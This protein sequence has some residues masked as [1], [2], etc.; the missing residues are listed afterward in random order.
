MARLVAD[1]IESATLSS[2][3]REFASCHAKLKEHGAGKSKSKRKSNGQ[4]SAASATSTGSHKGKKRMSQSEA[5]Q[6]AV[7]ADDET[8]QE[9]QDHEDA[10]D[11]LLVEFRN[12]WQRHSLSN[13]TSALDEHL[14]QHPAI[15]EALGTALTLL[16]S[17]RVVQSKLLVFWDIAKQCKWS[18]TLRQLY[19]I[20]G[21]SGC[22]SYRF[23]LALGSLAQSG[24]VTFEQAVQEMRTCQDFRHDYSRGSVGR[25]V[26]RMVEW[27]PWDATKA[28]ENFQNGHATRHVLPNQHEASPI[29]QEAQEAR[30]EQHVNGSRASSESASESESDSGSGFDSGSEASASESGSVAEP[31]AGRA[32]ASARGDVDAP[33]FLSGDTT[34]FTDNTD[35]TI[36]A[37]DHVGCGSLIITADNPEHRTSLTASSRLSIKSFPDTFGF[38]T[39]GTGQPQDED[40]QPPTFTQDH[41]DSYI[42][43][44]IDGP[45][46]P[47]DKNGQ[48]L[49]SIDDKDEPYTPLQQTD[50]LRDSPSRA[51]D[52][53]AGRVESRDPAIG[54]Q[55]SSDICGELHY[56]H[57]P[58]SIH[59]SHFSDASKYADAM[60]ANKRGLGNM[61]TGYSQPPAS[62]RNK[63]GDA[64]G[65]DELLPEQ[66]FSRLQAT[67]QSLGMSTS[68]DTGKALGFPEDTAVALHD[69][70][71]GEDQKWNGSFCSIVIYLPR[72]LDNETNGEDAGDKEAETSAGQSQWVSAYVQLQS[73]SLT[74]FTLNTTEE[75]KNRDFA[76]V[77]GFV[78]KHLPQE[79][80]A[81]QDETEPQLASVPHIED[82]HIHDSAFIAGAFAINSAFADAL[83]EPLT[84]HGSSSV[85]CLTLMHRLADHLDSGNGQKR[86]AEDLRNSFT[87]AVLESR[88]PDHTLDTSSGR[89]E[90][91]IAEIEAALDDDAFILRRTVAIQNNLTGLRD[92]VLHQEDKQRALDLQ[93]QQNN[94]D[95][96]TSTIVE[97]NAIRGMT[98]LPQKNKDEIIASLEARRQE[99]EQSNGR[100]PHTLR[101]MELKDL[102]TVV[103]SNIDDSRRCLEKDSR[104]FKSEAMVRLR[105][106]LERLDMRDGI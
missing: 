4:S 78:D 51:R 39:R 91:A 50:A 56:K 79:C 3:A 7:A 104:K 47:H 68:Q 61:N 103:R 23:F 57:A 75:L 42:P 22:R 13:T 71:I 105:S 49:S 76:A 11:R 41:E 36:T 34:S 33:S 92:V 20:F 100:S 59:T 19:G 80:F 48:P 35:T 77:A 97:L 89:L 72:L 54:A 44:Q 10:M 83:S 21:K 2:R 32:E 94:Q 106:A 95:L 9:E 86:S 30:R 96:L 81:G 85:L 43:P 58:D 84:F 5:S 16:T 6:Y 17:D 102:L 18:V 40:D 60:V 101:L 31:E 66:T 88:L 55:K 24:G 70:Q 52:G 27:H 25:G 45:E 74:V 73:N 46:Q 1:P 87:L 67:F 69:I 14:E 12:M 63:A 82:M 38:V 98:S 99:L 29:G 62:K 26:D 65:I 90:S 8:A 64:F 37:R 93:G 28:L 53:E 15:Q